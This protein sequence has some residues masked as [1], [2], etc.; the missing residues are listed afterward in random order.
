M[1]MN[2]EKSLELNN[3]KCLYIYDHFVQLAKWLLLWK[4]AIIA[5]KYIHIQFA[6]LLGKIQ[7]K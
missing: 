3:K 5:T 1:L 7:T 4:N 2:F 6:V